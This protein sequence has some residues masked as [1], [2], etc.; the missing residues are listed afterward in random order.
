MNKNKK[1]GLKDTFD[2][3]VLA[4]ICIIAVLA[5]NKKC[6]GFIQGA[7]VSK[8]IETPQQAPAD[9]ARFYVGP[10]STPSK[11]R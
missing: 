11:T 8:K 7:P 3:L 10:A 9:T 6:S 1:S 5:M 2:D 4:V